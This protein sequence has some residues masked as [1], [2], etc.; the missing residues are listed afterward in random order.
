MG[1]PVVVLLDSISH[2]SLFVIN[3]L[4]GVGLVVHEEK[5]EVT[6]VVDDESLVAGWHQVTGLLVGTVSDLN[7]P[8]VLLSS[9]C[10]FHC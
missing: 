5:V 3:V 2:L 1:D 4:G 6:G 10:V 9:L 7:H 8:S